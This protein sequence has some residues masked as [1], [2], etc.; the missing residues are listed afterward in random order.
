MILI[1]RYELKKGFIFLI[2]LGLPIIILYSIQNGIEEPKILI[3]VSLAYISWAFFLL[4]LVK[5]KP[6]KNEL[7]LFKNS[8]D[9]LISD[10]INGNYKKFDFGQKYKYDDEIISLGSIIIDK[11][12]NIL[13]Y[14]TFYQLDKGFES[15]D[16]RKFKID[17]IIDCK[18]IKDKKNKIKLRL[19]NY[20]YPSVTLVFDKR[21]S[22]ENINN[23]Y[24]YLIKFISEKNN[25]LIAIFR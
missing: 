20:D 1:W 25:I 17:N 2:L 4:D 10:Y 23:I 6:T 24:N 12:G 16:I 11:N 8:M 7:K 21:D 5:N 14:Q 19:Q 22:K 15:P 3:F 9:Y 13:F 18:I